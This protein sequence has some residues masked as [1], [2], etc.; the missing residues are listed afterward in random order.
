MFNQIK[1][2]KEEFFKLGYFL[3]W[4]SLWTLFCMVA[5]THYLTHHYCPTHVGSCKLP[6]DQAKVRYPSLCFLTKREKHH[7]LSPAELSTRCHCVSPGTP[8]RR[9]WGSPPGLDG[10][11]IE[12]YFQ[13][14]GLVDQVSAGWSW[15][16]WGK[17][18]HY[19]PPDKTDCQLTC[20]W[21]AHNVKLWLYWAPGTTGGHHG[22]IEQGGG[23]ITII[24]YLVFTHWV[25]GIIMVLVNTWARFYGRI[26]G[27]Q[28][29]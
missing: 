26:F 28:I 1:F 3:S 24:C 21:G 10:L 8:C 19:F 5:N 20:S 29:N 4:S 15:R 9:S 16:R 11:M 23:G 27:Y 12:S 17:L 14:S 7:H 6:G 22:L 13:T 25:M 2:F 18:C